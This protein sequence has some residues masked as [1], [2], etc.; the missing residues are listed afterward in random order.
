M[1]IKDL[2]TDETKWT[3]DTNARDDKNKAVGATDPTACKWGLVA[4][5][6]LCYRPNGRH[7]GIFDSICR[8]LNVANSAE[9]NTWNNNPN[10]TFNDISKIIEDLAI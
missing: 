3:Q 8:R 7:Y 4:A 10:R 2:L 9:I 5:V 6:L 1:K